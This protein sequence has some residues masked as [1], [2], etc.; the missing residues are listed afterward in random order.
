MPSSQS[1]KRQ[2]FRHFAA[3]AKAVAHEHRLELIE[4]LA[5][6][7]RSVESLAN[8]TG[9]S[10]ANAS[11][12]LQQMRRAGVIEARRE[13]KFTFYRLSDKAVLELIASLTRI[14]ERHV[15]EVD[16]I[17]RTYFRSRDELEPVSRPELIA[18]MKQGDVQIIDV[19]PHDEFAMGHLPG[20][21][22]IPLGE[23]ENE[24]VNL[25]LEKEVIA[26]CRG[27]YCILS[28]DMVEQLRTHGFKARRLEDGWPEWQAAGLPVAF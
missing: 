21:T 26:Y 27:A 11:Q 3:V 28:F 9:L 20:A 4:A 5:Q 12:H 18:R 13:G 19:R 14:G 10:V 2:L 8:R 24:F 16:R 1:P 23:L 6:G 17:V 25:D 15:A 22:N 7:E